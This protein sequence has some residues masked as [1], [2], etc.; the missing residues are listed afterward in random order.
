MK[1]RIRNKFNVAVAEK[2]ID[3]LRR[4]EIYMVAVNGKRTHLEHTLAAIE[5][6]L[7]HWGGVHVI[8]TCLEIF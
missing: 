4:A 2:A 7:E 6:M 5:D 1:Q 8:D 3:K